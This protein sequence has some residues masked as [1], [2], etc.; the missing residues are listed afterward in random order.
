MKNGDKTVKRAHLQLNKYEA[1]LASKLRIFKWDNMTFNFYLQIFCFKVLSIC[2]F[3]KVIYFTQKVQFC[4]HR[5]NFTKSITIFEG[6]GGGLIIEM[7][8]L[9]IFILIT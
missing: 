6:G 4:Q 9:I 1:A 8:Q 3:N 7:S 5:F 2:V